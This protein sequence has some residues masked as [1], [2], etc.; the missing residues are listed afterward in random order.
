MRHVGDASHSS[1]IKIISVLSVHWRNV[2]G[3]HLVVSF[4]LGRV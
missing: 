4:L 1:S 2:A 3:C